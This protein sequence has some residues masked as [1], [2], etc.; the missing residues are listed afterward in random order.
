[1]LRTYEAI[2]KGDM[3]EWTDETPPSLGDETVSVL[4]TML[5]NAAAI[6]GD[7]PAR[8]ARTKAAIERLELRCRRA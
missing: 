7:N 5:P 4:V 3:L 1:M 6:L 2:M 8:A